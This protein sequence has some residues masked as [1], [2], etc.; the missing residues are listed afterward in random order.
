MSAKWAGRPGHQV[1]IPI[2]VEV[3]G[4]YPACSV[5]KR[6]VHRRLKRAVTLPEQQ[7]DVVGARTL[8]R[9][10]R[11]IQLAIPVEVSNRQP[12]WGKQVRHWH[13][14]RRLKCAVPVAQKHKDAQYPGRLL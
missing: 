4:G 5:E 8:P 1:Q 7:R 11:N 6:G 9:C 10:Y 12:R 13:A 2:A 14:N 3:R